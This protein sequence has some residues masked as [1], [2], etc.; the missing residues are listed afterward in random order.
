MV[1][2]L[3]A[4]RCTVGLLVNGLLHSLRPILASPS[5]FSSLRVRTIG[6]RR[7]PYSELCG[8][9]LLLEDLYWSNNERKLSVVFKNMAIQC[10]V[11]TL[12]DCCTVYRIG[13]TFLDHTRSCYVGR[14]FGATRDM[15]ERSSD[16][17][18][19]RITLSIFLFLCLYLVKFSESTH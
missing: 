17:R 7:V 10:R 18:R 5:H 9:V 4:N 14:P 12:K 2:S 1:T 6:T 15:P 19:S 3:C 13:A 16:E 11:T 8:G